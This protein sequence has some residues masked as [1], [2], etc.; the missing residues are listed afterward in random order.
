MTTDIENIIKNYPQVLQKAC[1]DPW[2]YKAILKTGQE[3]DFESASAINDFWV[4][5]AGIRAYKGF[6]GEIPNGMERGI[7]VRISEL[8]CLIDIGS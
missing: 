1:G 8:S 5:L 6:S 4:T 2:F 3:I 7:D